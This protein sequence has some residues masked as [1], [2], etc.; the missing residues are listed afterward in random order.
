M[1][2]IDDRIYN[3]LFEIAICSKRLDIVMLFI[4]YG[5]KFN[6]ADDE[7]CYPLTIACNN[8]LIDITNFLIGLGCDINFCNDPLE[9]AIQN[10]DCNMVQFLLNNKACIDNLSNKKINKM[11]ILLKQIGSKCY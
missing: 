3:T 7:L 9:Y 6:Y 1:L 5:A 8:G 2:I 4:I 11:N 10:N